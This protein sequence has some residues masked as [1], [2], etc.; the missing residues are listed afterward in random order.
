MRLIYIINT[1]I[2]TKKAYGY[3]ICK[4]CEALAG[5]GA[6]VELWMPARKNSISTNPFSFYGLKKN[7]KI[8]TINGFDFLSLFKYLGK[9]SYWLHSLSYFL[10]LATEKIDKSIII[11]TRYPEIAWF[12]S[13]KGIKTVFE[14]HTW[15]ESKIFLYKFLLRKVDKIV[16]LTQYMKEAFA[17]HNFPQ[18]KI[19]V[20]PDAVDLAEFDI[21]I[22]QDQARQT[23]NLP[24]NKK[25]IAYTG[26]FKT[27]GMDKGINDILKALKIL[28]NPDIIFLAVGG[29]DED[30]KFYQK[31]A[32]DLNIANQ[33]IFLDS[34]TQAQL[35]QYQKAADV[36]LM[37][38]P[39]NE[40]YAY[41]MSPLKM[42][43]Y[44]VAKRPIIASDLPSIREILNE[45]NA[46]FCQ[47]NDPVTLARSISRVLS[48]LEISE[49]IAEKSYQDVQSY[50]WDKRVERILKFI[51]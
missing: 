2:P 40:H 20:S 7:F 41:F 13:L 23:L 24:R 11:Y 5:A 21:N 39:K 1:K 51:G 46:A 14:A 44:M 38:F 4:M 16:V 42:F 45:Q 32:H 15:P 33:V 43:E 28:N 49:Q 37:P 30:I 25:I 26:R 35:A 47:P 29:S 10:K 18:A 34:K 48:N 27:M 17:K 9:I 3:Q 19:L 12:F 31:K 8:K 36:L 6:E 50:S 22:S